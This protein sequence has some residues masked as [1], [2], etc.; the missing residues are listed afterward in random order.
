[1]STLDPRHPLVLDLR[2]LGRQA[3]SMVEVAR[4]VPAP[5]ELG[6][7]VA[8]VEPGSPMGLA[9]RLEAVVEGVLASGTVSVTVV[10]EC[11]RC[12]DPVQWDETVAFTELFVHEAGP[13]EEELPQI[14]GDLLDL[15]PVV[16]DVV[17]LSLPLA[18][19]CSPD[20]PGLC[21]ECGARLADD[22]THAH[23][24]MDPRWAGLA[25]LDT[26]EKED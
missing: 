25:G 14:V 2:E 7:G 26:T 11:A 18:P 4:T 24:R 22:P 13:E 8:L 1:M 23:D 5:A 9:V 3:G 19:L 6:A 21:V 10:G 15:E 12:L 17:V 16:R 20:C